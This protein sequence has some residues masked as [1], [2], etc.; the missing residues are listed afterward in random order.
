MKT[1]DQEKKLVNILESNNVR[2]STKGNICLNDFVENVIIS[3]NADLYMKK[4]N[5]KK[6]LK[7]DNYYIEPSNCI[8]ILK[9]GKS[10]KMQGNCTID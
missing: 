3:K 5:D 7:D 8:D 2:I 1:S 6:L 4:I 10:K 9:Q